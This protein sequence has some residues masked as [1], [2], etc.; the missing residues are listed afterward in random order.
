MTE[1]IKKSRLA[2]VQARKLAENR[3]A[4]SLRRVQYLL[5]RS[6]QLL[7]IQRRI[8][9]R[10]SLEEVLD[11]VI[12]S[13]TE[14]LQIDAA[15]TLL[16]NPDG[17]SFDIRASE[18]IKPSPV[19][20]KTL[21]SERPI[22]E[23]VIRESKLI[24]VEDVEKEPS[25]QI[26]ILVGDKTVR[27]LASVPLRLEDKTIGA[28]NVYSS[29][30]KHF[31]EEDIQ[32]LTM[33]AEGAA[34]A[35]S[36]ARL[37]ADVIRERKRLQT[38]LDTIPSGIIITEG[39][40]ARI[41]FM[42]SRSQE[43]FGTPPEIG[44]PLPTYLANSKLMHPDG[45]PFLLNDLP[46]NRSMHKGDVVHGEELV[47]E[48]ETGQRSYL[49]LGSAPLYDEFGN[50]YGA[51]A[52]TEDITPLREAQQALSEA[53]AR[54]KRVFEELQQAL[55][56]RVPDKIENLYLAS[57]Y[58]AAK[59]E[60]Q[61]GGDFFDVFRPAPNLVGIVIGDVAGKGAEAAAHT[62]LTR[63]SLKAYAYIDPS[64]TYVMEALTNAIVRETP[65]EFFVTVFYGLLDLQEKTLCYAS[66]GHEP[67]LCLIS[68][69]S[70]IVLLPSTGIP[71]GIR[72]GSTYE[73]RCISFPSGSR[74]ML[75]TD[76]VTEARAETEFFGLDRLKEFFILHRDDRPADFI[77]RL[78]EYVQDF[79][80]YHLR[81]DIALML[82]EMGPN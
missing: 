62:A 79:A 81:D 37:Y 73:Q 48:M 14:I 65:P 82:I 72:A 32:T 75:Y 26:P 61:I 51:V 17:K 23:R 36:N 33:F 71:L 59:E 29:K 25:L 11:S 40:E 35:V 3:L 5:E 6:M 52:S 30:P 44:R 13:A 47:I 2:D 20:I 67:S 28:L 64:P 55:L 50:I 69:N 78:L 76:G 24:V 43:F 21:I 45:T 4:Q 38:V 60:A 22:T 68:Q 57:A 15:E 49:L 53:Y 46:I 42:N 63:H 70:E 41:A 74:I 8:T 27:A 10:L 16:L 66:A 31:S 9:G 1:R 56:P 77:N 54:E 80:N 12:K 58:R 19:G 18:S 39:P 7:Q 34:V